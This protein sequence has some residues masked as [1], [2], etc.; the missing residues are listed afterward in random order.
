MIT[1]SSKHLV[2]LAFILFTGIS[3]AFSQADNSGC[4]VLLPEISGTYEGQCKNGLADGQGVSSGIDTYYGLFKK[5]LPEGKGVY[6]FKNG[7]VFIGLFKNGLKDGVGEYRHVIN[8]KDSIVIG[9]WKKGIYKRATPADEGYRVTSVTGIEYYS[10]KKTIDTVNLIEISFEK[11]QKKYIPNDLVVTI[12]SGYR[13]A[14]NL[15]VVVAGYSFP[16]TCSLRFTIPAAG[17]LRQC[18]LTF[19]ILEKGKWEVFINNN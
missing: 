5:G 2:M 16:V 8:G 11:Y 19:T 9:Y 7:D 13:P 4:K 15:K 6:K 17:V 1:L 18:N 12:T 10:I 14:G 3:F